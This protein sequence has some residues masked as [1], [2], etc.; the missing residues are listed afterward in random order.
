MGIADLIFEQQI[1]PLF[2]LIGRLLPLN[3]K[4]GLARPQMFFRGPVAVQAPLHEERRLLMGERHLVDP[5][6]A[7]AA[8]DPLVHMN[9]VIEID[10][11]GQVVDAVPLERLARPITFSYRFEHVASHPHLRM[12]VHACPGGRYAG[13]RRS[14]H[15][16]VAVAAI[17]PQHA[18]VMLMA[19]RD[20]LHAHVPGIGA[21]GGT[22]QH[23]ARAE[24]AGGTKDRAQQNHPGD[25]VGAAVE[26]LG[27]GILP[28]PR[29]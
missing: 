20:R 6:M 13:K 16:S 18:D 5:A 3:V 19:E 15:R 29:K 17:D 25:G 24:Q 14:L 12:A 10:E 9:A 7:G 28:G 2:E 26:Y 1:S 8:A 4:H 21:V 27:H 11:A 22:D 23:Q